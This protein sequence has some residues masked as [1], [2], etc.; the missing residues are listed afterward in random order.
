MGWSAKQIDK[1]KSTAVLNYR[2]EKIGERGT[3]RK[4]AREERKKL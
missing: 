3:E 1:R 4:R 2:A